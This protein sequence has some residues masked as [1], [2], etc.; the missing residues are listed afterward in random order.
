MPPDSF[1]RVRLRGVARE[2]LE[3]NPASSTGNEKLLDD[4]APMDG[5]SIPDYEQL[6]RDMAQEVAEE[7]HDFLTP[8]RMLVHLEVEPLIEQ[9]IE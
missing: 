6:A 7:A 8:D 4:F 3:V 5:C 1:L 2:L 9:F